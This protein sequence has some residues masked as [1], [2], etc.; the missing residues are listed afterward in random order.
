MP[1]WLP[2]HIGP[3]GGV[4]VRL[5]FINP[6]RVLSHE[7]DMPEIVPQAGAKSP[8]QKAKKAM[9][10]AVKR[11]TKGANSGAK[12]PTVNAKQAMKKAMPKKD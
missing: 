6:R 7:D 1:A 8:P 11:T 2:I 3:R 9:K 4:W 5:G 12:P 10:S